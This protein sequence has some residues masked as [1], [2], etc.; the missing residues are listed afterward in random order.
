MT[1]RWDSDIVIPYGW[2]APLTKGLTD[3]SRSAIN[4]AAGKTKL[5][6]WFASNCKDQSGRLDYVTQLQRLYLHSDEVPKV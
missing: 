2:I 6:A 4:H 1:H 3:S 5:V